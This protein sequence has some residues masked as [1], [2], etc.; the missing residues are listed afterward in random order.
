MSVSKPAAGTPATRKPSSRKQR[1]YQCH[2]EN[3]ASNTAH[4]L[5]RNA[6]KLKPTLTCETSRDGLRHTARGLRIGE[7]SSRDEYR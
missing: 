2:S 3:P 6:G 4:G 1:L 7:K 5:F